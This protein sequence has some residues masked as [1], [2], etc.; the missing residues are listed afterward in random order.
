MEKQKTNLR[1]SHQIKFRGKRVK[2]GAWLHGCYI[3]NR[4]EHF[5]APDGIQPPGATAWDFEVD[6]A[7]VGQFTGLTDD[8]GAD[9]YEGD[10]LAAEDLYRCMTVVVE[11]RRGAFYFV[12]RGGG[13]A[14]FFDEFGH[15]AIIG[16]IHDNPELL[17]RDNQ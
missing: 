1:T 4:G 8:C 3:L 2:D 6:P 16:N 10:I 7:T 9:I 12:D 17:K 11:F 5:I 14:Y 13:I 15:T